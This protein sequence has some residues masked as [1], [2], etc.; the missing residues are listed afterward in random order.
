[1]PFGLLINQQ[2]DPGLRKQVAA[3]LARAPSLRA[4]CSGVSC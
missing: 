2:V 4:L 1:M 3:D